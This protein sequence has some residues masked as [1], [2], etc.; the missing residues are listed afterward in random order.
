MIHTHTL[1]RALVVGLVLLA[2][3]GMVILNNRFSLYTRFRFPTQS[4]VANESIRTSEE[5]LQTLI[6]HDE[7][8]V[9]DRQGRTI[10]LLPIADYDISARVIINHPYSR[11]VRSGLTVEDLLTTD[12]VLGWGLLADM[13]YIKRISFSHQFL[14]MTFQYHDPALDK[15]PGLLYILDHVSSNHIIASNKN[16]RNALQQIRTYDIV[17]IRGYLIDIA[18]PGEPRINTSRIRTDNWQRGQG[19]TGGSEFIYVTKL[20]IGNRQYE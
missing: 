13:N 9:Q 19:N 12:L 4:D 14:Y 7:I 10:S 8:L 5:P 18:I 6:T 17:R 1:R 16:I 2:G 3:A 15:N 20:Q 11:W